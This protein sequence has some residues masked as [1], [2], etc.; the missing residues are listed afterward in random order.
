MVE[1][2]LEAI[3]GQSFEMLVVVQV[4]LAYG[5]LALC[6]KHPDTA[7]SI[8]ATCLSPLLSGESR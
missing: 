2:V 3:L 1:L 5:V 7:C 6:Q 4:V 8:L